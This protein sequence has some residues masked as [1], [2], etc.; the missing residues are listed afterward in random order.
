MCEMYGWFV[1][2]LLKPPTTPIL[3]TSD[4]Q[5]ISYEYNNMRQYYSYNYHMVCDF[6]IAT[7]SI[8]LQKTILTMLLTLLRNKH[9]CAIIFLHVTQLFNKHYNNNNKCYQL[10]LL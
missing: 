5:L 10:K 3:I 6:Q 2:Q 4:V 8:E 9:T 1:L 7:Q